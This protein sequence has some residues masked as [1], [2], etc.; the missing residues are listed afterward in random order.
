MNTNLFFMLALLT[1]TPC[2]SVGKPANYDECILENI[3]KAQ[4]NAGVGAVRNACRS[5]FPAPEKEPEFVPIPVPTE[6]KKFHLT[7]VNVERN[8]T[9]L[10]A[11]LIN[12]SKYIVSRIAYHYKTNDCA[13][14]TRAAV[15][16][17]QKTL[18]KKGFK[19][20]SSDGRLGARTRS[21]IEKFQKIY[22]RGRLK[23]TKKLDDATLIA[24]GIDTEIGWKVA[25]STSYHD[26][27]GVIWSG[28]SDELSFPVPN[29]GLDTC[30]YFAGFA[31]VPIAK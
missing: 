18:N 31:E 9:V 14:P 25:Y 24:L 26:L 6:L 13:T 2:I 5:L 27:F 3:S 10:K 7:R 16:L 8:G 23:V 30:G 15:V 20:G 29:P 4:T 21:A 28:E 1:L 12:D 11:E 17:A 19:A 22:K